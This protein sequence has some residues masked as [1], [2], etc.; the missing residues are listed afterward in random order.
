M[1]VGAT[2][3]GGRLVAEPDEQADRVRRRS[4]PVG[5]VR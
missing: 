1:V 3:R 5:G 2:V 4:V